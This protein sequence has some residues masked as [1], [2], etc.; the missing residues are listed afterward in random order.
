[1]A[2]DDAPELAD[3]TPAP[4]TPPTRRTRSA[5]K[6]TAA[7][8]SA[9]K[10]AAAT[11]KS[12]AKKAPAGKK[13]AAKKAPAKR[14]AAKKASAKVA[15]A[16]KAPA[17]ALPA[18]KVADSSSPSPDVRAMVVSVTEDLLNGL[19]LVLVGDGIALD[20]LDT[21]VALPGMGEVD[22]R[23]A[24]TITGGSVMPSAED[25]GRLRVVATA[26]GDVSARSV[27]FT[28]GPEDVPTSVMGVPTPPAP[29]P[30]RVE[31]LVRPVFE[32]KHDHSVA[33]G[34]DLD[35]ATLV[36]LGVDDAAPVPDGVDEGAWQGML[37]VFG[38]LFGALG[39]GLWDALAE[40]VGTAGADLPADVGNSLVQLGVLPG[41]GEINVGSGLVTLAL[42]GDGTVKGKAL[43][44]P[45]AGG[46]LGVGLASSV[47]DR[48]AQ[49]L[50]VRMAGD[51]PVPFELEVDLGEQQVA[52]RLRQ[53]RLLP[54][55]LP[56]L[57]SALRTEVRTRL[58]RGR[59]ELSVE[60]AWVELPSVLP[61][62]FNQV[63]KRLGSLVSLAPIRMRFPATIEAPLPEGEKLPVR[64]DDLRVTQDGIGVVLS[65]A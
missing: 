60:S 50:L 37:T 14:P 28:S 34:L 32:I 15:P 33:V 12:V 1:M 44:V 57:R 63:S 49:L 43:P 23:V 38:M 4:V 13:P 27:A 64:V 45:V 47:V 3:K 5:T 18:T 54:D 40:H 46:R 58:V 48:L 26:S 61:P 6:P 8:A 11:K 25:G 10:K 31:A 9:P 30:V 39:A 62:L 42:A 65:L 24:L 21:S 2:D 56:D 59:L 36:S 7:K 19:A 22:V 20:P 29:I 53:P 51:L 17:K 16:K 55:L 35:G 52:G 41:P